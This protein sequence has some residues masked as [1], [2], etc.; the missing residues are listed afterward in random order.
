[1]TL[2]IKQTHIRPDW[3]WEEMATTDDNECQCLRTKMIRATDVT[4][5]G[6]VW[7]WC[8]YLKLTSGQQKSLRVRP[9]P[10]SPPHRTPGQCRIQLVHAL[11]PTRCGRWKCCLVHATSFSL[12]RVPSVGKNLHPKGSTAGRAQQLL[13][14]A[15]FLVLVPQIW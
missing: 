14:P 8:P 3:P 1:M 12:L 10:E 7:G 2:R 13:G 5:V 15:R 9:G 11:F 4:G 6:S